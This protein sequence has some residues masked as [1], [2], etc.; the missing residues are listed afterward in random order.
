M[1][2]TSSEVKNRYNKK[3]YKQFATQLPIELVDNFKARCSEEGKSQRQV[4]IEL[5]EN[6]LQG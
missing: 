5:I 6:Y 2:Y 4:I 3:V 1:A